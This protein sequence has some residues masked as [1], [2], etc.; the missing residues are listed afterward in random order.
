MVRKR[1]EQGPASLDACVHKLVAH[2]GQALPGSV[3]LAGLPDGV[4][5]EREL[6]L[7]VQGAT[8]KRGRPGRRAGLPWQGSWLDGHPGGWCG[9]N[10]GGLV[11]DRVG[12]R[13]VAKVR[14]A[15]PEHYQQ[16]QNEPG[17]NDGQGRCDRAALRVHLGSHSQR[18]RYAVITV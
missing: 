13:G 6:G 3:W 16:H 7:P 4:C 9:D 15:A 10:R 2:E 17:G 1:G 14:G 8:D 5:R 12:V 11:T 18:K